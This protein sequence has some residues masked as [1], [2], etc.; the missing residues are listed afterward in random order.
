L[1]NRKTQKTCFEVITTRLIQE[2][3]RYKI[4]ILILADIGLLADSIRMYCFHI[5]LILEFLTIQ[6]SSTLSLVLMTGNKIGTTRLVALETWHYNQSIT[7]QIIRSNRNVDSY[8]TIK[9]GL[10][11]M[12][13]NNTIN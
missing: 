13:N 11:K 3:K 9:V 7:E 4:F 1:K 12:F 5:F 6:V 10:W 2:F 8:H